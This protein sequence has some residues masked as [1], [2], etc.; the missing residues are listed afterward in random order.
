MYKLNKN[1]NNS[2]TIILLS[3]IT[4]FNLLIIKSSSFCFFSEY[5]MRIVS[6]LSPGTRS[7]KLHCYKGDGTDLGLQTLHPNEEYK[8]KICTNFF[9]ETRYYCDFH[10]RE[11]RLTADFY[12]F[13]SFLSSLC[14]DQVF[15]PSKCQWTVEYPGF[16]FGM[17]WP[18]HVKAPW[19]RY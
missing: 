19:L 8:F 15:G 5:E 6:N 16:Y 1:N 2:Q 18:Y 17:E 3:V 10:W 12:V 11:Y 9:T 13:D 7:L 4:T 14:E